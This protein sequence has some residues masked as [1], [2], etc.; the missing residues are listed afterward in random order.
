MLTGSS[1]CTVG[2]GCFGCFGCFGCV[3]CFGTRLCFLFGCTTVSSA[4]WP[5]PSCFRFFSGG[6]QQTTQCAAAAAASEMPMN[7]TSQ[8]FLLDKAAS[9]GN[10]SPIAR[11]GA[12]SNT[13]TCR[14][15]FCRAG[16]ASPR[17]RSS[18]VPQL[19]GSPSLTNPRRTRGHYPSAP[20][21]RLVRPSSPFERAPQ[22]VQVELTH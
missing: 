17:A 2:V 18:H 9:A 15:G 14:S 20:Q 13:A 22:Q 19:A 11:L 6:A 4:A 3:G 21:R 7:L 16:R 1:A 10:S 12:V 5:P 8:A